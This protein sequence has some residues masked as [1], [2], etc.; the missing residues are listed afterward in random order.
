MLVRSGREAC[1]DKAVMICKG[2]ISENVKG[3]TLLDAQNGSQVWCFSSGSF[4]SLVSL[5]YTGLYYGP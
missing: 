2:C 5:H 4:T 1:R 3:V